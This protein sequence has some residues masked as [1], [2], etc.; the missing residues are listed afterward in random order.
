MRH[1][2]SL[3]DYTATELSTIL[4]RADQM[5]G[6]WRSQTMPQ[7]LR[8][9]RVALWFFGEGFRNRVAFELGAREMGASVAYMPGELGVHEPIQDI[10]GY[11]QNWFSMLVIRAQRHEDL[12]DVAARSAIPVVNARTDRGHPCEIMGDLLYLRQSGR[13]LQRLKLVFVGEPSNMCMSWL[14]AAT[15]FPMHVVQVC[16]PGFEVAA[17]VLRTFRSRAAGQISVTHDLAHALIDADVI[18]TDCWPKAETVD[19]QG[20]IRTAFLPYQ[21]TS[22]HLSVL[23][24]SGIFLPCP[25]VTRGEEVSE[26]AMES[27]RCRNH[28]AKGNLLHVQN[29]IMEYLATAG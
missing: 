16:P 8:G 27:S 13:D 18:Y 7:V 11:L 26:E 17:S 25:P 10:A 20:H 23:G 24:E 12:L 1:F 29:A 15:V 3:L 19:E 4:I 6:L 21:I 28:L 5:A 2:L 14:E 22:K 9:K